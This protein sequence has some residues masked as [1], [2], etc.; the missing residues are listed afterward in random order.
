M[1]ISASCA[2]PHIWRGRTYI[3]IFD[4]NMMVS[5]R[6]LEERGWRLNGEHG[7]MLCCLLTFHAMW[8][9]G[10]EAV[11]VDLSASRSGIGIVNFAMR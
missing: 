5:Q 8:G 9:M 2:P 11:T 1:G 4:E 7:R 6:W 10:V 3:N